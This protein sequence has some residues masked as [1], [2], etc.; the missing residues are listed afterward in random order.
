MPQPA[1]L[2]AVTVSTADF[3]TGRA[4]YGA[5]LGA[6]GWVCTTE[7]VDEEEDDAEVEALGW[8][9]AEAQPQLWLIRA[10]VATSGLH[11]Q[12]LV[13][14]PREVETFVAAAVSSGGSVQSAPRRWTVY[15]RGEYGATVRDPYG[16]LV[17]AVAPE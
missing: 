4:F 1:S 10:A 2:R 13:H 11:L 9:P 12:V 15:R 3:A 7:L 14:S 5:V 16:N 17:E 8:G 6:L